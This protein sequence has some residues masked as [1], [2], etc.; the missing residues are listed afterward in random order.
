MVARIVLIRISALK[1]PLHLFCYRFPSLVQVEVTNVPALGFLSANQDPIQMGD[2]P[3]LWIHLF[4]RS[5]Y[6][7]EF[8]EKL[9]VL[10]PV[11]LVVVQKVHGLL[12]LNATCG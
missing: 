5:E 12:Y 10:S 8:G 9:F 3:Q 6:E 1:C 7:L 2:F 11:F 4:S